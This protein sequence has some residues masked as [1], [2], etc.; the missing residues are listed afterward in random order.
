MAGFS[1]ISADSLQES[2]VKLILTD[3]MLITSGTLSKFDSMPTTW[4]LFGHVWQKPT[5]SIVLCPKGYMLPYVNTH[6]VVTLSFYDDQHREALT[7]LAEEVEDEADKIRRSGLTPF[8]TSL[9]GVAFREARL[10]LE[11]EKLYADWIKEAN[12]I[13]PGVPRDMYPRKEFHRLFVLEIKA[14]WIKQ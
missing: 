14:V 13:D 11:C 3:Q 6:S 5:A 10:L 4:A 2:L 12:F 8:E 9:G 1:A 7:T